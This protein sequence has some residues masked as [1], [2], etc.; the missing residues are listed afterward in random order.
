MDCLYAAW[1]A[2]FAWNWAMAAFLHTAVSGL[3]FSAPDYRIIDAGP[4]WATGGKWGPE[5]GVGAV[6]GMLV[7]LGFLY[8]RWQRRTPLVHDRITNDMN[9]NDTVNQHHG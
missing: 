7:A 1:A 2:H 8:A 6:V 4:D 3:P 5:G 9:P